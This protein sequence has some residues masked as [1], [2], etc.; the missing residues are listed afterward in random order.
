MVQQL[1]LQ[2]GLVGFHRLRAIGE[3][4]GGGVERT[5]VDAAGGEAGRVG[6]VGQ[7][8]RVDL[9]VEHRPRGPLALA[10]GRAGVGDVQHRRVREA[11]VEDVVA[12]EGVALGLARVAD[13]ALDRELIGDLQLAVHEARPVAQRGGVVDHEVLDVRAARDG[14]ALEVHP[15]GVAVAGVQVEGAGRP[16]QAIGEQLAGEHHLLAELVVRD[17]LE[18]F[19]DRHRDGRL[20]GAEHAGIAPVGGGRPHVQQARHEIDVQGVREAPLLQIVDVGVLKARVLVDVVGIARGPVLT[21]A[22]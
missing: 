6:G 16:I 18:G 11:L 5:S 15:A 13:A 19:L 12:G 8:V 9:V 17:A 10:V 2:A 1:G 21:G 14:E 7:D 3:D 20:A 4:V 22:V